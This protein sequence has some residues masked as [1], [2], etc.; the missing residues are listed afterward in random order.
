MQQF[1]E[2]GGFAMFFL[3]AFGIATLAAAAVYAKRLTR[4][5]LRITVALGLATTFTTLTGICVDLA[6]VGHG[7][8][9][10]VARHPDVSLAEALLQGLAESLAPGVLG[11]TFVA[12]AA[13]VTTL[14]LYR[15]PNV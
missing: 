12:L 9:A 4:V 15:E 5:T 7:A 14:G 10:Y 8:S 6:A 13:L 1:F 3:L 2:E 11:F